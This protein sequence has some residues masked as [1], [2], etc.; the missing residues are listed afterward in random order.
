MSAGI[1]VWWRASWS[2]GSLV[3]GSVLSVHA[4]R[5][6]DRMPPIA[7]E[8]MSAAQQEAV[9]ELASV[10]GIALRGPWIPLLRSPEVMRRARA[11][12]DYLRYDS[13]LPARFSEFLVLLTAR[14]WT[15][16]YEW[17]AHREIAVEAGLDP[18]IV[19]AIAEGRRPAGMDEQEAALYAL[20]S[21]LVQ[22]RGVSDATYADAVRLFGEP[23]VIDA[24]GIVGYYTL[25]AMV[26]NVAR[27]PIPAG[28]EPPLRAWPH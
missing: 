1:R 15:Q 12:G 26:M 17:V 5:A 13:V 16:Q 7:P 18:Q 20:H 24:V 23:G 19:L 28:M 9:A 21:E 25:L 3:I 2:I 22:H 11:M 6:Q 4:A 10:R 27:T 14:E 8:Q